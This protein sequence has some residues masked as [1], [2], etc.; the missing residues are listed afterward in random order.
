MS[1]AEVSLRLAFWLVGKKLVADD[2]NEVLVAL[3]GAQV[4]VGGV[5]VF[6]V[7]A[8]LREN[9]WRKTD[10]NSHW[11]GEYGMK[12]TASRLVVHSKSGYGDVVCRFQDGRV[13]RA[14]AK[15]GPLTDSKSSEEY[16]LIREALGQLLTVKEASKQDI[17]AVAVP[18]SRRFAKLAAQWRE[19]P[20]I[21]RL[22]ILILTVGRDG[23]VDGL[24]ARSLEQF[25]KQRENIAVQETLDEMVRREFGAFSPAPDMND[26]PSYVNFAREGM[27]K[28]GQWPL[29]YQRD[30]SMVLLVRK[31]TSKGCNRELLLRIAQ[32]CFEWVPPE[33]RPATASPD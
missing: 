20:L 5:V 26:H 18:Y 17:L 8:F 23:E 16:P 12:G 22:G 7:A 14:E 28:T 21:K 30:S 3:D 11:R 31:W 24:S 33:D 6:D 32:A 19:A 25:R 2:D 9:R 4:K 15:K 13:F 1:E 29:G 10:S 27:R